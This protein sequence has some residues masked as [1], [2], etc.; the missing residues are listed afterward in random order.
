MRNAAV[1]IVAVLA[2]LLASGVASAEP[3]PSEKAMAQ[4]LFGEGRSLMTQGKMAEA[5]LKLAESDRLDPELG[6]HLN[7]GLCH[8]A[9]GLTATAWV[10]LSEVADRAAVAHDAERASFARQRAQDLDKKLSRVRL[11]VSAS[12]AQTAGMTLKLDGR[13]VGQAAWGEPLPLD[14]GLHP[15]EATAPGKRTWTQQV[16]V[17]PGPS[18]QDVVIPALAD[19]GDAPPSL[20]VAPVGQAPVIEPPR[21]A[22][23]PEPPPPAPAPA[24]EGTSGGG[25]TAGFVVGGVGLAAIVVGGVFGVM[26]FTKNATANSDCHFADRGCTLDGFNAGKDASTFATISDFGFGVGLAGVAAGAIL[27]LTSKPGAKP[28]AVRVLPITMGSGGGGLQL[29]GTW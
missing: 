13:V 23:T 10:E 7:L 6:T 4:T 18:T 26:T 1:C 16:D 21:A 12:P 8:E 24:P 27:V 22:P 3:S 28:A 29:R 25:R 2:G 19:P 9:L 11:R 20:P 14:P 5:C 15:V 17:R